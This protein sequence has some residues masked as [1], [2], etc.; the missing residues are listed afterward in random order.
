[1]KK[2]TAVLVVLALIAMPFLTFA[3]SPVDLPSLS[4]DELVS[5]HR[6]T[7]AAILAHPEFQSVTV[8][9]GAYVVGEDIPAGSYAVSTAQPLAMVSVEGKSMYTVTPEE[10]VGKLVL[11]DGDRLDIVNSV[12]FAPY[13][14]L[15]F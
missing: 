8:P 1:M 12:T 2:Q 10:P 11:S 6:Q 14:G 3:S 15:G 13:A 7:Y 9:S 5:L 4:W